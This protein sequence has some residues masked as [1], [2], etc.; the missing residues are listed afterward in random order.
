[1]RRWIWGTAV[2]MALRSGEIWVFRHDGQAELTLENS[3]YLEKT[4]LKP[5][6]TKQVVLRAVAMDYA[7]RIRWSLA[8]AQETP[9]VLRDLEDG[10]RE[11]PQ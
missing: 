7:T 1:M 9:S 3:V 10:D 4:R 6:A 5:R 11:L 8:K 2:S